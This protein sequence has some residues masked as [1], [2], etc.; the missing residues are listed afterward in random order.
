LQTAVLQTRTRCY[1]LVTDDTGINST[2]SGIGHDI[3]VYLDGQIIN[4][5]VLNDFYASGE[6]NGCLS[7][8]LADYQKGNV[9]Y[10]FRNLA[11]GQHQLTFKVWDI[12]NNS[13]TATLNFEVKDEADQHLVINRP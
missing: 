1:W 11:V 8:S 13:T 3:T 4:T 6:G 5:I 2:G 7:P 10:P 9:T 12:N